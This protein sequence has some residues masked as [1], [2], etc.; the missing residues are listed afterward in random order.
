MKFYHT[1]PTLC[2]AIIFIGVATFVVIFSFN[3]LNTGQTD[4]FSFYIS[5]NNTIF[6]VSY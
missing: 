4:L 1:Q 2:V 3:S 6:C 5:G